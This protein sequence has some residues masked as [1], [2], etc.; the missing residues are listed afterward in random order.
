MGDFIVQVKSFAVV[1][2]TVNAGLLRGWLGMLRRQ[3]TDL[4]LQASHAE[5]TIPPCEDQSCSIRHRHSSRRLIL[6]MSVWRRL[7]GP[8]LSGYTLRDTSADLFSNIVRNVRIGRHRSRLTSERSHNLSTCRGDD[9]VFDCAIFA[10]RE[11]VP[12]TLR[13]GC[14][15]CTTTGLRAQ[16]VAVHDTVEQRSRCCS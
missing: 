9:C 4:N 7:Q 13:L 11:I 6:M 3:V 10:F 8:D 5:Q 1:V 16:M 2:D 12:V 15:A 14:F